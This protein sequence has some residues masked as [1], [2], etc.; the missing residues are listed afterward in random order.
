MDDQEVFGDRWLDA[1]WLS[2][3]DLESTFLVQPSAILEDGHMICG[4]P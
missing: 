1:V 4:E 3:P 2:S